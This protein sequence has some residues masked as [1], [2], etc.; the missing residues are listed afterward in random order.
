MTEKPIG[1]IPT[2]I[3]WMEMLQ[4]PLGSVLQ[5]PVAGAEIVRAL[6]PPVHFYRYLY[7]AVGSPWLWTRRKLMD[8]ETLRQ[9][10]QAPTTDIRVLWVHGVPAGYT[11]LDFSEL[12]DVNLAY[13]GLGPEFTGERLGPW[14]LDWTIRHAF[15]KGASRLHLN[16]CDLD[17]PK[18]LA[19]Y[20]AAGFVVYD[21]T[22]AFE[23]V[24]EGMA[25]PAHLAGRPLLP[26]A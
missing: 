20:E 12:P 18:A 10:I 26:L 13:F 17:H 19:I 14:L 7:H 3:T 5:A 16:T 25:V 23:T 9:I 11:E 6:E 15:A 1:R 2:R 4:R 21:R 24:I 22:D 8:D